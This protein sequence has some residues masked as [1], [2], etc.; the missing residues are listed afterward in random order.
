MATE[1]FYVKVETVKMASTF[2]FV[3]S[4]TGILDY[5]GTATPSVDELLCRKA[6]EAH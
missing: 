4:E 2:A 3:R 6:P 1:T 5:V